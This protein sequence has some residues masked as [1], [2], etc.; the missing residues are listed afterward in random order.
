MTPWRVERATVA[1]NSSAWANEGESMRN[2]SAGD[3]QRVTSRGVQVLVT[4]LMATTTAARADDDG[5]ELLNQSIAHYAAIASYADTGTV[6]REMPGLVDR[7]KFKT[8]FQ[9]PLNFRFDFQG[10]SS[11]SGELVTE[12]SYDHIVLWMIRGELQTYN[13]RM[14]SHD[15]IP[16]TGNQPAELLS[17][18]VATAGTSV[19]IPSLLYSK[20]NLPGTLQQIREAVNAGYE[21]V[22]G[23]RCHKIIATAAQYYPSGAKTNVRQVTVWVDTETRLLRKVFEDTS[24]GSPAGTYSRLTVTIDPV[25]NPTLDEGSFRFTIPASQQ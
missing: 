2:E 13:Q 15:V 17:A 19:L 25:T 6:V 4:L 18:S 9:R 5:M 8:Y 11:R 16:P 3:F 23:H 22:G 14:R 10:V 20:A 21:T 7:W 24:E 12:L 1:S